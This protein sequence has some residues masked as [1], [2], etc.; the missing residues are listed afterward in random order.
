MP[1]GAPGA[2]EMPFVGTRPVRPW[3]LAMPVTLPVVAD[4]VPQGDIPVLDVVGT[5]RVA[6]LPRAC[7][8]VER[9][10]GGDPNT[11]GLVDAEAVLVPGSTSSVEP[12]GIPAL[13]GA[14]PV[15]IGGKV[16][17]LAVD[18]QMLGIGKSVDVGPPPSKVEVDPAVPSVPVGEHVALP[19]LAVTPR[20][21]G[22]RPPGLTS[23]A[24]MGIPAGPAGA[25][26]V[27]G[28]PAGPGGVRGE[29]GDGAKVAGTL[30]ARL[31]P[32]NERVAIVTAISKRPVGSL[33][34]SR[35]E[36]TAGTNLCARR[37]LGGASG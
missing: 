34:S 21:A 24:P 1:A 2:P 18:A 26:G 19:A 36:F 14:V 32:P 30:C 3:T 35:I 17:A 5:V 29:V 10:E 16:D 4:V 33:W 20:V 22:P 8:D 13:A 27:N 6:G 28:L 15:A 23:T 11:V 31:G 12:S 25:V 9:L 7:T 37:G